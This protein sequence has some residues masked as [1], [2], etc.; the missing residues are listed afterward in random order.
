MEMRCI[1]CT[2]EALCSVGDVGGVRSE[3]TLAGAQAFK[4]EKFFATFLDLRIEVGVVRGGAD[5]QWCGS[6][7]GAEG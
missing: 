5:R 1:E 4:R 7:D 2:G 6:A 3:L